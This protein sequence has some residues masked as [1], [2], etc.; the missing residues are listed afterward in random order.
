M[1]SE[2]FSTYFTDYQFQMNNQN[3][4]RP[5]L[6]GQPG[7][8]QQGQQPGAMGANVQTGP[9]PMFN[10]MMNRPMGPNINVARR[11]PVPGMNPQ[12]QQQQIQGQQSNMGQMGAQQQQQMQQ[13]NQ[14]V[15]CSSLLIH[16]I[17]Y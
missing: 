15:V 7:Q 1:E 6:M 14:P 10:N 2:L 13:Q 11:I 16:D 8:L 4:I 17:L 3:P 9:G 12:Q 5:N